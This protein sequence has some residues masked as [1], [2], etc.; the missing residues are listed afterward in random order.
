MIG[1]Y[2]IYSKSQNKYYIGKSID[3]HKRFLK[4]KSDLRLNQHH[5]KYLQNV[6]NKYGEDDL[7]FQVIQECSYE[8]SGELEKYYIKQFNSFKDGFNETEGGEWGAPGRKFSEETLKKMSENIRGEKNPCYNKWGDMNPHNKISKQIASY[9]YFF[10]HS[11]K[12]FPKISR[13]DFIGKY[14]ITLD[15]YKKIQQN[16]TWKPLK[17]EIDLNDELLYQETCTFIKTILSEAANAERAT[18]S[19]NKLTGA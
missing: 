15:I 13:K 9:I 16:K 7:V 6:Y 1:I 12:T 19:E 3:I 17:D 10:T 2:S 4:H 18:T 8:E 11:N 14:G 5:S